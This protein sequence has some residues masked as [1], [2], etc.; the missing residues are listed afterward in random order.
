MCFNVTRLIFQ[1][2]NITA[3]LEAN[4]LFNGG[5]SAKYE[6][7]DACYQKV[8]FIV[9]ENWFEMETSKRLAVG[10]IHQN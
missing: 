4:K 9:L 6:K 8:L 10:L 2:Q 5:H 3:S 7:C 1:A